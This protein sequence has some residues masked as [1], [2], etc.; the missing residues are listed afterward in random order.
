[1]KWLGLLPV[2]MLLSF[3]SPLAYS[4]PV[5]DQNF[6]VTSHAHWYRNKTINIG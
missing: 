4:I 1:M 2:Y 6:I 3:Y 5:P